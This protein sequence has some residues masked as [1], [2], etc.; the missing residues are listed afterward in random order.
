LPPKRKDLRSNE[1]QEQLGNH[2]KW[3]FRSRMMILEE[4]ERRGMG[5][6]DEGGLQSEC[7]EQEIFLITRNG[8]GV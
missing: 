8:S 3:S 7:R 4:H 1:V 5:K 2:G 6:P